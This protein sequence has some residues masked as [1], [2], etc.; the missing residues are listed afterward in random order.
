MQAIHELGRRR[1]ERDVVLGRTELR[2]QSVAEIVH[3]GLPSH[4]VLNCKQIDH[5]RKA[6]PHNLLIL[7]VLL[8]WLLGLDSNQQ[9]SAG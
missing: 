2:E 3:C 5:A 6:D 4:N 1:T 8:G 7:L 9:P